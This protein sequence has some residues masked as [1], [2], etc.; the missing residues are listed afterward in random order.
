MLAAALAF[1]VMGHLL[2]S[3]VPVADFV[4]YVSGQ[5]NA[6]ILLYVLAGF[7]AALIDGAL[8]MAYGVSATT[9]LLSLGLT[10]L[11]ASASVH[12]SEIFTSGA[13]GL[14]HRKLGNVNGKLLRTLVLPG[15]CGA[16]F[17]AV[18]LYN[19]GEFLHL[20][21][22]FV[23]CYTLVLGILILRKTMRKRTKKQPMKRVGVLAGVGGFLDAIGGGGW[24][25]IV[26]STLIAKG[27]HPLYTI[28]SSN[29]AKFFVSFASSA[30]FISLAGI[31]H[32]QVIL[33]L[34]LGGMVS[35]PIGAMLSRKLPIKT[36][37]L[38]VG[39]VVIAASLR[40]IIMA[41]L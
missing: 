36:T 11:V 24:G 14:M 33:G 39:C 6:G 28:G 19:L 15:M 32:W 26:T 29:M 41:L 1:M 38:I 8:G 20:V 30:T 37:M 34:V 40:L 4:Q 31:S 27:R 35:A 9:F 16:V 25:P 23:A 7:V 13:S 5:L 17:G 22:P 21:K 18:L 2:F 10:P 3:Y 12:A